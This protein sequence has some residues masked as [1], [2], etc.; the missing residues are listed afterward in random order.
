[1]ISILT[2]VRTAGRDQSFINSLAV[3]RPRSAKKN[4]LVNGRSGRETNAG[5]AG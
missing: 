5:F 3:G 2:D 1:M 4:A